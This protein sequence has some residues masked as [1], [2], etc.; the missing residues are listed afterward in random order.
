MG[1]SCI[2]IEA[3]AKNIKNKLKIIAWWIA[4]WERFIIGNKEQQTQCEYGRSQKVWQMDE[5]IRIAMTFE[6]YSFFESY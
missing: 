1:L 2:K 5:I 4:K 6:K 3:D